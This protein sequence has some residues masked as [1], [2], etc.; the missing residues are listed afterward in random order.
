MESHPQYPPNPLSFLDLPA[1]IRAYTYEYVILQDLEPIVLRW[2]TRGAMKKDDG[3]ATQQ[4]SPKPGILGEMY[5]APGTT[6]R[7]SLDAASRRGMRSA[8]WRMLPDS[9]RNLSWI[10]T[11]KTIY[12]D[13]VTSAFSPL[14]R[15]IHLDFQGMKSTFL[16]QAITSLSTHSLAW[17][18]SVSVGK[19]WLT[20]PPPPEQRYRGPSPSWYLPGAYPHE[21]CATEWDLLPLCRGRD[22]SELTS[23]LN[24]LIDLLPAL[25]SVTIHVAQG[26]FYH[27][28]SP[29]TNENMA[30]AAFTVLDSVVDWA[31]GACSKSTFID[32]QLTEREAENYLVC[33]SPYQ[34]NHASSRWID[35]LD[36]NVWN[37]VKARIGVSLETKLAMRQDSIA[38]RNNPC[39]RHMVVRAVC[40]VQRAG[41]NGP[42]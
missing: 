33:R 22:K 24:I 38:R 15:N 3:H 27:G 41:C 29:F 12:H 20:E 34:V 6:P 23:S 17:I 37:N 10:L 26:V 5:T 7:G 42:Y 4:A 1:E 14:Y 16:R 35:S 40:L 9:A 13:V 30:S 8:H 28:I 2:V 36:K 39:S 19:L 18:S 11:C 32:L 25:D 21:R 31:I